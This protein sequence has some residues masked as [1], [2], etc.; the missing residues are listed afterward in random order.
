MLQWKFV[1]ILIPSLAG[2]ALRILRVLG[3]PPKLS[4]NPMVELGVR[5]RERALRYG[6]ELAEGIHSKM[7]QQGM[8]R[9]IQ[10]NGGVWE[11]LSWGRV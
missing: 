6:A 2:R 5:A 8:L 9:S 3:L 4:G 11:D 10:S 7:R 1:T